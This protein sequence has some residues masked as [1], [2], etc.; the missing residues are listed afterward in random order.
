M[1]S[2]LPLELSLPTLCRG[3]CPFTV[4]TETSL[5]S[6]SGHPQ[7]THTLASPCPPYLA[8]EGSQH[9][10]GAGLPEVAAGTGHSEEEAQEAHPACELAEAYERHQGHSERW[11]AV[12][13][14]EVLAAK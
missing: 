3:Y 7:V 6:S 12:V 1:S 9:H 8:V 11:G 5:I 4:D 10:P 2:S 13:E 14:P